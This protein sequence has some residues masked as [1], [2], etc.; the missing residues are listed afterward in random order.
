MVEEECP[1]CKERTVA[2]PATIYLIYLRR[3]V[4]EVR[5]GAPSTPLTPTPNF[6]HSETSVLD[7]C[8]DLSMEVMSKKK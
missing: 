8:D 3:Q 4:E 1:V 5:Q 6:E 2:H 7:L